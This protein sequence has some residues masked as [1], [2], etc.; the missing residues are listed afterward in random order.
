MTDTRGLLARAWETFT[1]MVSD[2]PQESYTKGE[3]MSLMLRALRTVHDDQ[4]GK[5]VEQFAKVIEAFTKE[6]EG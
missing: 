5:V 3:L 2:S 1:Q 4:F 6:S